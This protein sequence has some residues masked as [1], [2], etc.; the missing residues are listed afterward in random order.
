M[1]VYRNGR[2][3]C[4]KVSFKLPNEI[5]IDTS[6]NETCENGIHLCAP[7]KSFIVQIDFR[8][9]GRNA[10]EEI[11]HYFKGQLS[12]LLIGEIE[13]VS[14]GGL[15]GYK[16]KYEDKRTINEEYIFNITNS[17]KSTLLDIYIMIKK[18]S[19][20][21]DEGYKNRIVAEI[22]DGIESN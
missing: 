22:L 14:T 9:T 5:C 11:S 10:Y 20:T 13:E 19:I 16:A 2:L 1:L 7:D 21:Y 17:R 6:N 4:G 18:S 3:Y 8:E 12:Y 15:C